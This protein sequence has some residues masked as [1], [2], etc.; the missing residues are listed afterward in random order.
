LFNLLCEINIELTYAIL[1]QAL[2]GP[3]GA[4]KTTTGKNSQQKVSE[5]ILTSLNPKP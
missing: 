5:E 1:M 2:L 3:N 4:G